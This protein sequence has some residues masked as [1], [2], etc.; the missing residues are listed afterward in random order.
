MTS[1]RRYPRRMS[2]RSRLAPL[3]VVLLAASTACAACGGKPAEAPNGGAPA[4]AKTT[5]TT[6]AKPEASAPASPASK[7]RCVGA[8]SK[9]V[10]AGWVEV[11]A[12]AATIEGDRLVKLELKDASGKVVATETPGADKVAGRKAIADAPCKL[13]G[14]LL[15]VPAKEQPG[16]TT[17]KVYK[18]AKEDEAGDVAL[19]CTNPAEIPAD[20]DDSQRARVAVALFEERLTS[21]RWRAWLADMSAEL[22]AASDE[23]GWIA[24]KR[25]RAPELK[26][27]AKGDC[28][29]A[30]QLA[31]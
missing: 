30:T 20:F 6:Q 8:V 2:H 19:M 17:L 26:S 23:A 1:A 28:W 27:A 31:R 18:P 29:F 10:P 16:L 7:G 9:K 5:E 24:I 15:V 21:S 13:G 14:V 11:G 22:A 25:K 4:P 3:A 12:V